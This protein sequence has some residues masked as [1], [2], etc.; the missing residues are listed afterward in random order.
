MN[1]RNER[2]LH[3]RSKLNHR[4]AK[5]NGEHKGRMYGK[6]CNVP[7][8]HWN[9]I[10]MFTYPLDCL[11]YVFCVICKLLSV[12]PRPN[13]TQLT[14]KWTK[15]PKRHQKDTQAGKWT[16]LLHFGTYSGYCIIFHT[17]SLCSPLALVGL[18]LKI[19]FFPEIVDFIDCFEQGK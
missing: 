10:K 4:P 16:F 3:G 1:V 12:I 5:A 8:M 2:N 18:C 7:N 15:S 6:L 17:F 11:P 13:Q 14:T 9:A 19:I